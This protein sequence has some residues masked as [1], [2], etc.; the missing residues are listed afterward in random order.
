MHMIMNNT[1]LTG[2][3]T[4]TS[5][6]F[7]T[8][9]HDKTSSQKQLITPATSTTLYYQCTDQQN[10]VVSIRG[11]TAWIFSPTKTFNLPHVASG[12]GN[13]YSN[14]PDIYWAKGNNA[15]FQLEGRPFS[16]CVNNPAKAAWEHAKLS[17]GDF[18]ALG[19]EPP[20][21]LEIYPDRLELFSGYEK[22]HETF[23][24]ISVT[25]QSLPPKTTYR[26][27]NGPASL[28]IELTPGPCHDSMSG[29]RFATQVRLVHNGRNLNGCGNPL[30]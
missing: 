16:E 9:C 27:T 2:L 23:P 15:Y 7:L 4:L 30:H 13:R 5:F 6:V 12:S 24:A 3:L 1:A 10:L 21:I 11:D 19:N 14:G 26:G 8:A 29:E 28:V 18:R 22:T 25:S 20:W 17:G